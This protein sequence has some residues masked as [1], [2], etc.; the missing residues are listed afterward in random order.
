MQPSDSATLYEFSYSRFFLICNL[1]ILFIFMLLV[2]IA[3]TNRILDL[4]KSFH[5]IRVNNFYTVLEFN[6]YM[7]SYMNL[8]SWCDSS[9]FFFRF[10]H[11]LFAIT[12]MY[13]LLCVCGVKWSGRG[14][15][16][17]HWIQTKNNNLIIFFPIF[18]LI[19][20]Y[21]TV[22]YLWY[23]TTV[24]AFYWHCLILWRRDLNEWRKRKKIWANAYSRYDL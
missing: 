18:R 16:R 15:E 6:P 8:S 4:F 23:S 5:A 22:S 3:I 13:L 10:L 24:S 19:I 14:K 2:H 12:Y 17:C 9:V 20:Y 21:L 7:Y 1:F 11:V